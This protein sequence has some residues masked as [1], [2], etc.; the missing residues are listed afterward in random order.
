MV[1]R[2]E[3]G[4]RRKLLDEIV[5]LEKYSRYSLSVM[6]KGCFLAS[7]L[8]YREAEDVLG[9]LIGDYISQSAIGR[10]VREVGAHYHAEEEAQQEQIFEG[11]EGIEVGQ[12]PA[13]VMYGESDGVWIS[14]QREEKQNRS[15][16]WDPVYR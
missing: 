5:G 8:A 9:W 3:T 7:E 16:N 15:A 13:K 4:D 11:A 1:Y 12:T 2:D 10:M 14:L 6:Q